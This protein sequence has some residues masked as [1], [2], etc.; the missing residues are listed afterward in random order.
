MSDA[1][2]PRGPRGDLEDEDGRHRIRGRIENLLPNSFRRTGTAR[3][4]TE[5]VIRNAL[6]DM[7]LPKEV[8][9]TLVDVADN[10]K[11]E[12]VRVAAREFREFLDS[13]RFNEEL[14][15]ILTQL[16][17]EIRTEI[18]FVPN[19]QA[20]RPMVSTSA[21]VKSDSGETVEAGPGTTESIN[22]AVR[23]HA[24]ELVE[25]LLTRI[26]RG[27][28]T[29]REEEQ[30][31]GAARDQRASEPPRPSSVAAKAPDP[32][33]PDK[34]RAAAGVEP[35]T[36]SA[37]TSE[38]K[39]EAD[40]TPAAEKKPAPK[41]APKSASSSTTKKPASTRR[42]ATGTKPKNKSAPRTSEED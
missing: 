1:D 22:E 32:P 7:K 9:T 36:A 35:G 11:K 30:V 29:A 16:S 20:L 40:D 34:E 8:V 17:F 5:D 42:K 37:A 41:R 6:G 33:S 12:V 15:K 31:E 10:T 14:A 28:E 13:A 26:L 24:T 3:Q 19:D 27:K 21:Q 39:V 38:D 4:Y 18:R 2:D 23:G 25:V